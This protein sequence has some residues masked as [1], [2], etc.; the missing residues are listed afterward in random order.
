VHFKSHKYLPGYGC[1]KK[2]NTALFQGNGK[3]KQYFE[4]WYFKM[5]STDGTSILSIIPGISLAQKGEK[6][7]AFIQIIDGNT[8]KTYYYSYPIED[9][10]FSTNEFAVRIGPNFFSA[11]SLHLNIQNDSVFF[12]GSLTLSDQTPL[13]INNAKNKAIMGWYRFMPFMQ[14]YHGVVSLTH[15]VSGCIAHNQQNYRFNQGQGYIEKDWGKS[16]P[17]AWIW[18]QSNNFNSEKTS[19]MLSVAH[20]PWMGASFTGFLGFFHNDNIT[21]RFGTY[22]GAKIILHSKNSDTLKITL[23][24]KK[25]TYQIKT[26]R[27]QAGF[28]KAPL[29]G[30]MDRRIAESIDAKIFLTVTDKNAKLIYNGYTNIA[31]L[32]MVGDYEILQKKNKKKKV[33]KADNITANTKFP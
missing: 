26:V 28:L 25:Y 30:S 5:V 27:K 21:Q 3:R 8:A 31:G 14:C 6:Q 23:S 33:S 32:E 20:V 17:S 2:G 1:K 10:Y 9:F 4:G 13:C 16:M 18:M 15:Q 12:K 22:S 29:N 11:D 19:F 24:D 7:H